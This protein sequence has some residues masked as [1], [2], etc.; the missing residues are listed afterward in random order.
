MHKVC[1]YED[2]QSSPYLTGRL[3]DAHLLAQCL[4]VWNSFSDQIPKRL[5]MV[6]LLQMAEFVHDEI[7]GICFRKVYDAVVKIQV[8]T[9]GTASPS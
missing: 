4:V 2:G 1:D 5:R 8:S 6:E 7:I 9:F 3:Q